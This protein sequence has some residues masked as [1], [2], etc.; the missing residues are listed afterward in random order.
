MLPRSLQPQFPHSASTK[1]TVVSGRPIKCHQGSKTNK[2]ECSFL[3]KL[4]SVGIHLTPATDV[5]GARKF[6]TPWERDQITYVR[7][8]YF[9]ARVVRKWRVWNCVWMKEEILGPHK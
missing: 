2:P 1:L 9:L 6:S 5:G 8:F 7:M 4:S 3:E